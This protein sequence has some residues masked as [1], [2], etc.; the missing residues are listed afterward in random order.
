MLNLSSHQFHVH[1]EEKKHFYF[2]KESKL[3]F[4]YK[5]IMD[6]NKVRSFRSLRYKADRESGTT[7]KINITKKLRK[8]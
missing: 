5:K 7:Y 1:F 6:K 3:F 8:T 2:K 4:F